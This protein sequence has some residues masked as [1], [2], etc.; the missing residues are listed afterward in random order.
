[1]RYV[2]LADIHSNLEAFKA[3]LEDAGSRAGFDQIWCLGDVVG[4]GPDPCECIEFLRNYDHICIAGNHDWA[5]VGKADFAKFNPAASQACEWTSKQLG[6]DDADYL[7]NLPEV[8]SHDDFTMVHGSPRQPIREYILST[9]VARQNFDHFD[10]KYCL[11]GHSHVPQIYAYDDKTT[12]CHSVELPE[13]H[14]FKF[15]EQR[16]ILNPGGIGQPR[17]GNPKAG[18]MLYDSN[19][20]TINHYRV[21]YNFSETQAKMIKHN[22]PVLL[23]E[24]LAYGY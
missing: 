19:T 17:D 2:I 20:G 21:D 4:Y 8:M 7:Y 23:I 5:S 1:M 22:L 6:S 11:V 12:E 14:S 18:Y 3:V 13:E 15:A 16:L 9:G 10:T 24:R